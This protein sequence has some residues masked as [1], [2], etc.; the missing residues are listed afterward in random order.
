[1]KHNMTMLLLLTGLLS[2]RL[3][4]AATYYI[5]RNGSDQNPGTE[6]LP[7]QHLPGM[8]QWTGTH[9]PQAGDVFLLKKGDRWNTAITWTFSGDPNQPII[10]SSYGSGPKPII[11]ATG[12]AHALLIQD[13]ANVTFQEID[14]QGSDE[15]VVQVYDSSHLLFSQCHIHAC[16]SSDLY[17][18]AMNFAGDC[19]NNRIS[20]CSIGDTESQ[21]GDC[22]GFE[23]EWTDGEVVGPDGNIVEHSEFFG[24]AAN[25][26][27]M[28]T[29]GTDNI[30]RYNFI[31]DIEGIA[32]QLRDRMTNTLVHNNLIRDC[33][34]PVVQSDG[35]NSVCDDNCPADPAAM[36][37]SR[38]INNTIYSLSTD[39]GTVNLFGENNRD[40]L[41]PCEFINNIVTCADSYCI[42]VEQQNADDFV[43]DYNVYY[44]PEQDTWVF[45][46]GDT[47]YS[48]IEEWQIASG[49]D[50]HSLL[51]SPRL[52]EQPPQNR[53]D[54]LLANDSPCIDQGE[55][56]DLFNDDFFG[57]TRPQGQGWD[58]GAVEFT[59]NPPPLDGSV[60]QDA[61]TD[62]TAPDQHDAESGQTRDGGHPD[63]TD[64]AGD[65]GGNSRTGDTGGCSGCRAVESQSASS[66]STWILLLFALAGIIFVR[67]RI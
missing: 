41:G 18:S 15:T 12:A 19:D 53:G 45:Y 64:A 11:D 1:M 46:D 21:M 31:H 58:V 54:F 27:Y 42:Q 62:S 28:R 60:E 10:V 52:T 6:S 20:D 24:P 16:Q 13:S 65:S 35:V 48:T 59:T 50:S 49:Q 38:F 40:G 63:E 8:E 30:I 57:T 55:P 14:F 22:L 67:R 29:G 39:S 37:G 4:R 56:T 34:G 33:T 43:V 5:A 26:I 25:G 2:P 3:S 9:D 51:T 17:D 44:T 66:A 7:L 61:G 32:I 47:G 36:A 23:G